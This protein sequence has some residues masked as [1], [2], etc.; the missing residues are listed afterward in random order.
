MIHI[1]FRVLSMPP[2]PYEVLRQAAAPVQSNLNVS[3]WVYTTGNIPDFNRIRQSHLPCQLSCVGVVIKH[4]PNSGYI[5]WTGLNHGYFAFGAKNSKLVNLLLPL[6]RFMARTPITS[7]GVAMP[8]DSSR[9][10]VVANAL[11]APKLV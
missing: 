6:V 11:N 5:N 7:S 2:C 8:R 10:R 4:F 1:T 3:V 9:P